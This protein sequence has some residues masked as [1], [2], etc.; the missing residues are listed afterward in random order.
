M[1]KNIEN[2]LIYNTVGKTR[3]FFKIC[4]SLVTPPPPH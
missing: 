3:G 2:Q 4:L 1:G